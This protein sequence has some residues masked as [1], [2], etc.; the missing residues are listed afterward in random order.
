MPRLGRALMLSLAASTAALRATAQSGPVEEL[1]QI[2]S[3]E[4]ARLFD[5][6]I[7]QAGL[8]HP[9]PLVRR[10]AAVAIGRIGDFRGTPFLLEALVDPDTTV[11]TAVLFAL[12]V[13]RD[14]AAI[15]RILDRLND[16]PAL[17]SVPASEAVVTVARLGGSTAAD[18]LSALLRRAARINVEDREGL[19][20]PAVLEAWRL[21]RAAPV[22]QL[23]AI[24]QDP[25]RD[26][27]LRWRALFSLER[28]GVA[29]AAPAFLA[30]ATDKDQS[31]RATAVRALD[32]RFV[33]RAGIEEENVVGLLERA[34]RDADATVRTEA[35]R[36]LAGY[37]DTAIGQAV[38]PLIDDPLPNVRL[39]AAEALAAIGGPVAA[40]EFGRILAG[41]GNFGVLRLALLGLARADSARFVGVVPGWSGH[42]DWRYRAAAAAAWAEVAP[43]PGG[44]RPDFLH[45]RDP[46][47]VGA[48]LQGWA[49]A[50]EGADPG[51]LG[52]GRELLTSTDGVVRATAAGIVGRATD[53][54]DVP[55]LAAAYGMA[56]RDS[57]PGAAEAALAALRGI[58]EAS[59]VGRGRVLQEFL[60]R[61]PRPANYVLR[62]WA[63]D[64]WPAAAARWG[65]AFPL[66]TGMSLNDYRAVARRF[67]VNQGEAYP[68]VFVE[69]EQLGVLEL[70][71]F[72]P[73]A[74]LTVL[75]FLSL[76][77]RHF[78]DGLTWRVAPGF[79]IQD[80]DPRSDGWGSAP[81]TVRDE[82]NRR[83]FGTRSVGLSLN[84]PETG[85]SQWFIT[86]GPQPHLD[87]RYT[88]F[89]E[90]VGRAPSFQRIT[91]GDR[92]KTIHR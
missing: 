5:G 19:I 74:P 40:A 45:D 28:L 37:P 49:E 89:G 23:L 4:D 24:A 72:G 3:A 90:I 85:S 84:G 62:M 2:L 67:L 71:L 56:E 35:L 46:R 78:F 17:S 48:A 10:T 22:E 82:I 76:V 33:V 31:L 9:D 1:A 51:L 16:V 18:F 55:A 77:D 81:G 41:G 75:R 7:L 39:A 27:D 25:A 86:L 64:H 26:S 59:D 20:R 12:G 80:G 79:V 42:A 21:G 44:G 14:P 13:L 87:G 91:Q 70:E 11:Q 29:E 52:A 92:I 38:A 66:E 88:V 58:A 68:H 32:R 8:R 54:G 65:P 73:D 43:G 57:F 6:A 34:L 61:V 53:P 69:T 60:G 15:P 36:T 50:V 83:R 47:V 63:E 30:A